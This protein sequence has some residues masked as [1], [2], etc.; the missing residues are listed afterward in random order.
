MS[1]PTCTLCNS[2]NV[3]WVSGDQA[4]CKIHNKM[5]NSEIKARKK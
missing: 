1:K 4:L 3:V 5:A 2:K